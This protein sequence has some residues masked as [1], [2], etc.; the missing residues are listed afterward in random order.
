MT[1]EIKARIRELYSSGMVAREINET[2]GITSAGY[3]VWRMGIGRSKSDS[4]RGRKRTKY[5]PELRERIKNLYLKGLSCREIGELVNRAERTVAWYV[6]GT[7]I[8]RPLSEANSIAQAKRYPDIPISG[9]LMDIISGNL[10]GDGSIVNKH[11]GRS[12]C[13]L[14]GSKHREYI[15]WLKW[16]FRKHGYETGKIYEVSAQT[17]EVADRVARFSR[18]FKLA[19]QATPSLKGI[20]DKWY[21][22]DIKRVPED[23][24][25]NRTVLLHWY[26][27]DGCLGFRGR[28][29]TRP[30]IVL[31]TN[32][33]PLEDQHKLQDKLLALDIKS[34]I[35]QSRGGYGYRLHVNDVAPFF[36]VLGECPREL[37]QVYGYKWLRSEVPVEEK[38]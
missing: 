35:V 5:R 25:L 15:E 31:A 23:L 29:R 6:K 32:S 21:P 28:G 13:Y 11:S 18:V 24:R 36:A 34:S 19:S 20:R 26:L 27:G 4:Q 1:P 3:H 22:A 8:T 9:E 7:G 14:H 17:L 10:L 37:A 12:A 33:F 30:M 2:L 38:L 16:V